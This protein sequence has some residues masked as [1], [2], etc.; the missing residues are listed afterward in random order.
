MKAE[1]GVGT[2]NKQPTETFHLESRS[3]QFSSPA[4]TKVF[5]FEPKQKF[6]FV[7]MNNNDV[8]GGGI[9]NVEPDLNLEDVEDESTPTNGV[10]LNEEGVSV[11]PLTTNF[12]P[13]ARNK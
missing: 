8:G 13:S 10:G 1:V 5:G 6:D 9:G 11:L 7:T 3:P 4:E 2:A 12:N